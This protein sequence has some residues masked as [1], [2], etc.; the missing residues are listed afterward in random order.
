MSS[1]KCE[2]CEGSG[3]RAPA[4]PSC[5]IDIGDDWVIVERCDTCEVFSDD[6]SAARMIDTDAR[7]TACANGADH[8]VARRR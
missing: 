8:A 6:L 4:S 5:R 2:V 1:V 7:W 3:I